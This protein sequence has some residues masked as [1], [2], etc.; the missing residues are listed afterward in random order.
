MMTVEE[1]TSLLKMV[2]RGDNRTTGTANAEYWALMAQQGGW[3]W[4][5]AVRALVQ[6]RTQH[7]GTWMDPGHITAII[8]DARE[9]AALSFVVPDYPEDLPPPEYAEW[10]RARKNEHV[11]RILAGWSKGE[12]IPEPSAANEIREHRA[13]AGGSGVPLELPVVSAPPELRADLRKNWRKL[14]EKRPQLPPV[15]ALRPTPKAALDPQRMAEA[16]R[17]LDQIRERQPAGDGDGSDPE[18]VAS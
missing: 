10:Y 11:D 12:P 16:R 17:E 9:K 6:F 4:K 18:A 14:V 7:P 2:G 8:K 15:Q 13:L 3:T 1:L 5:T